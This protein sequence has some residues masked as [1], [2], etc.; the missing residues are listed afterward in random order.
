MIEDFVDFSQETFKTSQG[1][2]IE[3]SCPFF[4][5]IL[6]SSVNLP[7]HEMPIFF[8]SVSKCLD[9]QWHHF[10]SFRKYNT[11]IVIT[12]FITWYCHS[13]WWILDFQFTWYSKFKKWLISILSVSNSFCTHYVL[14]MLIRFPKRS[15]L[16]PPVIFPDNFFD[17][18]KVAKRPFVIY[19]NPITPLL[20]KMYRNFGVPYGYGESSEFSMEGVDETPWFLFC[21]K[22]FDKVYTCNLVCRLELAFPYLFCQKIVKIR[23]SIFCYTL[24]ILSIVSKFWGRAYIMASKWRLTQTHGTILVSME[25]RDSLVANERL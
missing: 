4:A 8:F 22:I 5:D 6:E 1:Q 11:S 10:I 7:S 17:Q 9:I 16:Q 12:K 19:T 13:T 14:F 2:L 20:T 18:P 3:N 21:L 15:L 25:R 24:C 23:K